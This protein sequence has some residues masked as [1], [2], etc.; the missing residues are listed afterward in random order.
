MKN[1]PF[2]VYNAAIE[3]GQPFESLKILEYAVC[4]A[5][6]EKVILFLDYITFKNENGV[7][8]FKID[9]WGDDLFSAL[10]LN[11][12]AYLSKESLLGAFKTIFYNLIRPL[13]GTTQFG[14]IYYFEKNPFQNIPKEE[15]ISRMEEECNTVLDDFSNGMKY[16]RKIVTICKEKNIELYTILGPFPPE[17]IAIRKQNGSWGEIKRWKDELKNYVDYLDYYLEESPFGNDYFYDRVH[18]TREAGK[19]MLNSNYFY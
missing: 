13:K 19:R 3:F 17:H 16:V 15:R 14:Y 2:P 11:F 5:P 7:K 18:F 6:I 8:D 1:F 9:M 12:L 4:N 10:N